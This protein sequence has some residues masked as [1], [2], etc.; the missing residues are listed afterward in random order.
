MNL[1]PS[2]KQQTAAAVQWLKSELTKFYALHGYPEHT[3]Q[4]TFEKIDEA[5]SDCATQSEIGV[6][7]RRIEDVK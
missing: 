4:T 1:C 3:T 5:F 2:C 6:R 7:E